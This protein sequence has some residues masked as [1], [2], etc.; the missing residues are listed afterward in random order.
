MM[1]MLIIVGALLIAFGVFMAWYEE[2]ALKKYEEK[3]LLQNPIL[4]DI[5]NRNKKNNEVI[6]NKRKEIR[7]YQKQIDELIE[8]SESKY[9]TQ[10]HKE[11]LKQ[12]IDKMCEVYQNMVAELEN[13]KEYA[14][15][16]KTCDEFN[17]YVEKYNI[18]FYPCPILT[19]MITGKEN[20][21]FYF[22]HAD[23]ETHVIDSYH[24]I[25]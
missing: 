3:V 18:C 22:F 23:E 19:Y 11:E 15:L 8:K 2:V 20:S 24:T 21:K 25:Y 14:E 4:L 7:E 12:E 13:S 17:N 1:T 9:L 10:N 6:R 16:L 5:V